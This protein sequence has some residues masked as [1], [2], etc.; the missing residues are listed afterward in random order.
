[1]K[2]NYCI[3]TAHGILWWGME[4]HK[5]ETTNH[6][7][8]GPIPTPIGYSPFLSMSADGVSCYH[9][10]SAC[11]SVI[12]PHVGILLIGWHALRIQQHT[13]SLPC[14]DITYPSKRNPGL[15]LDLFMKCGPK[16]MWTCQYHVGYDMLQYATNLGGMGK[17]SAFSPKHQ[18]PLWN[19]M[20]VWW[21]PGAARASCGPWSWDGA[22]K[23]CF[24]GN[25]SSYQ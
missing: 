3:T 23:N 11:L 22:G 20:A 14:I 1:M 2:N 7:H 19:S 9:A 18:R 5:K 10:K 4:H 16:K 21:L 25:H 13:Q 12:V 15:A 17:A 8:I 24:T 6:L